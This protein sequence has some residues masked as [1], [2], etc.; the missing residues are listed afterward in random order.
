VRLPSQQ[1]LLLLSVFCVAGII[2]TVGWLVSPRATR[3]TQN[4]QLQEL[5][6][7]ALQTMQSGYGTLDTYE[8]L[9]PRQVFD[10]NKGFTFE[11]LLAKLS[12]NFEKSPEDLTVKLTFQEFIHWLGVAFVGVDSSYKHVSVNSPPKLETLTILLVDSARFPLPPALN[13]STCA[14]I[15]TGDVILCDTARIQQALQRIDSY[16]ED[17]NVVLAWFDGAVSEGFRVNFRANL[18][19]LKALLRQNF[20]TWLIG[21]EIGHAI[22]HRNWVASS[23]QPLHFDAAYDKREQEAD[24][25]VTERLSNEPALRASFAPLLLEFVEQDFRRIIAERLNLKPSDNELRT[26]TPVSV[27][28][29]KDTAL[30]FRAL[31]ML[32][33]LLKTDIDALERAQIRPVGG[34]FGFVHSLKSPDYVTLLRSK[35]I[36]PAPAFDRDKVVWIGL[37]GLVPVIAIVLWLIRRMVV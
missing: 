33:T 15:G 14:Y 9:V 3:A 5:S 30:F 18:D 16:A 37:I 22:R 24:L 20:L 19:D 1:T 2:A 27:S 25:F 21:H 28:F 12:A 35:V 7:A 10:I 17:E 6:S 11:E 31:N 8:F 26:M 34:H 32:V 13:V 23:G 29:D 36:D 4:T